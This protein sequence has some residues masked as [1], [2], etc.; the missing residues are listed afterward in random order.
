M[1]TSTH[2]TLPFSTYPYSSLHILGKKKILCIIF[3]FSVYPRQQ[4]CG[5]DLGVNQKFQNIKTNLFPAS[6]MLLDIISEFSE[7][8]GYQYYVLYVVSDW[9]NKKKF[10]EYILKVSYMK[11]FVNMRLVRLEICDNSATANLC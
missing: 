4:Q 2:H 9:G 5:S 6:I 7:Q 1:L 10:W 8:E 11:I 3:F